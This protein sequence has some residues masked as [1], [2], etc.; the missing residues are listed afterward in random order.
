MTINTNNT[1]AA[2]DG[3]NK[4]SSKLVLVQHG[5]ELWSGQARLTESDFNVAQGESLLKEDVKASSGQKWLIDRAKLAPFQASKKRFITILENCGVRFMGGF[6]VPASAWDDIHAQLEEE[7]KTF[8]SLK[9]DFLKDYEAAVREWADAHPK[10]GASIL[11]SAP[12]LVEVERRIQSGFM[13]VRLLPVSEAEGPALERQLSGLSES[14]VAEVRT[15]AA[16]FVRTVMSRSNDG[17]TLTSV[18]QIETIA[19]KLKGLGFL[20][21]GCIPFANLIQRELQGLKTR[22]GTLDKENPA[23][24]Q[25]LLALTGILTNEGV[26]KEIFDGRMSLTEVEERLNV[27]VPASPAANLVPTSGRRR[28]EVRQ[29][30]AVNGMGRKEETVGTDG[31]DGTDG[32]A[33]PT[34]ASCAAAPSGSS[35]SSEASS[36]APEQT[37]AAKEEPAASVDGNSDA[38]S[39]Y[40]YADFEAELARSFQ[41]PSIFDEPQA[42]APRATESMP[43]QPVSSSGPHAFP[44]ECEAAGTTDVENPA[45]ASQAAAAAEV[46]EEGVQAPDDLTDGFESDAAEHPVPQKKTEPTQYRAWF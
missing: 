4:I 35:A 43:V 33:R 8:E 41:E 42:P 39:G 46:G 38:D 12:T 22:R 32:P 26:L 1:H 3:L 44:V 21:P 37:A 16:C 23:L 27:L 19:S 28:E 5:Y 20:A 18:R 45:A 6:A 2:A 11:A 7:V 36:P 14:L 25:K 15:A 40:G 13:G 17:S 31:S 24:F 34:D 9:A 30:S 29:A 10:L